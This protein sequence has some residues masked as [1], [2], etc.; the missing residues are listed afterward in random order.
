MTD[1]AWR[2]IDDEAKRAGRILAWC[3][4]DGVMTVKWRKGHRQWWTDPNEAS[5]YD[6]ETREPTHW[7][8]LPAPP[9]ETDDV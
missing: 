1:T 6:P 5:E 4:A 3:G 2:P 7:Q 8:H 9:K